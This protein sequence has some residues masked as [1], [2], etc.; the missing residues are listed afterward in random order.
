MRWLS[1]TPYKVMLLMPCLIL[2]TSYI[3]LPIFISLYYSFTKYTGIGTPKWIGISNYAKLLQNAMFLN[4]MKNSLVIL[5][6]AMLVLLP[7]SFL[8]AVLLNQRIRGTGFAKTAIFSPAIMAAVVVG[9]IWSYIF[10]PSIGLIN[11]LLRALGLGALSQQW[12]GGL[13]LTPYSVAIVYCW[14]Q[15]GFLATIFLAGIKGIP[16]EL[17]ESASL[18]GANTWQKMWY[19]TIPMIKYVFTIVIV[20]IINGTLKVFE[21]VL[22]LTNGGPNHYSETMVTYSYNI[23]FKNSQYGYGMAMAVIVFAICMV[24]S[25]MYMTITQKREKA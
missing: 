8:C 11:N 16:E 12:I 24:F 17:F 23:T 7:F 13:T 25:I 3:I 9:I 22:Q 18:E 4:S 5:L 1:K 19:I 6:V 2:Y 20:Q 21:V 15:T 14:Q 10:D